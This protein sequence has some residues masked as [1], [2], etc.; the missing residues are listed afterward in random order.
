[1]AIQHMETH[2]PGGGHG[3]A[4]HDLVFHDIDVRAIT[5]S[6][7]FDALKQGLADFRAKPSHLFVLGL[8]YP[9]GALV[10]AGAA[11]DRDVI[12]LIFPVISGLMLMGPFAAVILYKI[13]RRRERGL[14]F[15]WKDAPEVFRSSSTW[16]IV[17]LGLI[18]V[19][20][21]ALWLVAAQTVFNTTVGDAA[22][23]TLAEF[24][25][26]S[27]TTP[28]GWRMMIVG[29]AIGFLFAAAVL[30]TNIVSFPMLL[31]REEIGP[32]A[33]VA[34]SLRVTAKSPLTVALWG[35]IIAGLMMIGFL[36]F[37]VGLAVV[38]PLLGHATWHLYR[39]AVAKA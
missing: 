2:R 1:M 29:N 5:P 21:F 33:A 16:S 7:L 12:P 3:V 19:A 28:E 20:V 13:S 18:L 34:T 35:L 4:D 36:T 15:S 31:D 14:D 8:I 26:L 6:D 39:K 24:L 9:V 27:F 17:R 23:T 37:F 32:A 22:F 11:L 38:I 30:A 25:R 10:A